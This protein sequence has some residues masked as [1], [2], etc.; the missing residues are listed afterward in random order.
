MGK[1]TGDPGQPDRIEP[2]IDLV[3]DIGPGPDVLE[4]IGS[5][6]EVQPPPGPDLGAMTANQ[7]EVAL[8]EAVGELRSTVVEGLASAFA[9]IAAMI[10]SKSAA[11]EA[12]QLVREVDDLLADVSSGKATVSQAQ[13]D[14]LTKQRDTVKGLLEAL[15]AKRS[16]LLPAVAP[17]SAPPTDPTGT[18]E[19]ARPSVAPVVGAGGPA[20]VMAPRGLSGVAVRYIVAGIIV[21]VLAGAG[22]IALGG[23][24]LV[25]V[26]ASLPPT[27]GPTGAPGPQPAA[28]IPVV[29][30]TAAAPATSAPGGVIFAPFE[31]TADVKVDK[32]EHR[33]TVRFTV[34]DSTSQSVA[35]AGKTAVFHLLDN[36]PDRTAV[37][38]ADGTFTADVDEHFEKTGSGCFSHLQPKV[39]TVDGRPVFG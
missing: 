34:Q 30:A 28:T 4:D 16:A 22:I 5:G 11:D 25:P 7:L 32:C 13:V 33:Y 9:P 10:A 20:A 8:Q 3:G 27:S 19:P 18:P 14:E 21:A 12:T 36:E 2:Q 6:H 26:A 24:G 31:I 39:L 23:N 37:I 29:T 1:S 35:F 15:D 17:A 38:A